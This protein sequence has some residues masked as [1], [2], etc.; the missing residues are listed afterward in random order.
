MAWSN[1]PSVITVSSLSAFYS[2]ENFFCF[3][4]LLL[5]RKKYTMM[6]T[7]NFNKSLLRLG[8]EWRVLLP[9]LHNGNRRGLNHV[10][11][12]CRCGPCARRSRRHRESS[13]LEMLKIW[14][15]YMR[16]SSVDVIEILLPNARYPLLL[17]SK[18]ILYFSLVYQRK[19][20]C[21]P[22]NEW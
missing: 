1:R 2:S 10:R 3:E 7:F 13:I 17:F 16:V 12:T 18:F 6:L 20:I 15:P 22:K 19:I 14:L 8:W 11:K 9:C 5:V 4:I 21:Y